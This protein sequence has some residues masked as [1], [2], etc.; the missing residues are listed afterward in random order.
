MIMV[1]VL[2]FELSAERSAVA[3]VTIIPGTD[4][5]QAQEEPE[6]EAEPE[7]EPEAEPE[8][9]LEPGQ[10]QPQQ[11]TPGPKRI[12]QELGYAHFIPLTNSPGNQVKLLLN[13][14]I[15]DSSLINKPVNALMEVYGANQSLIRVSSF[16]D[17]IIANQSGTVQL[18]STFED[19]NLKNITAIT[20]F[21]GP[22]KQVSIS[23]PI[24][25]NLGLGQTIEK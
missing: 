9:E 5:N 25:I 8:P 21:T 10:I 19:E 3:Q 17:P 22:G 7:P 13:Y 18:A 4:N 14:T 20:T 23:N 15:D 12:T 1:L 6:P 11:T 16:S 24:N 2:S